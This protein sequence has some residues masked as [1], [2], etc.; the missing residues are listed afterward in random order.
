MSCD[1]AVTQLML[2][3]RVL[4]GSI[5]FEGRVVIARYGNSFANF[6]H[7]HMG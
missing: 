5:D 3:L 4:R 1:K 2:S 6:S 7:F